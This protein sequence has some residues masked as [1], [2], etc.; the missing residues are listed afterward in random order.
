MPAIVQPVRN[1]ERKCGG[2]LDLCGQFFFFFL[3]SSISPHLA[4]Q[5]PPAASSIVRLPR[6]AI[7]RIPSPDGRWMLIFECPDN[8]KPRKLWIEEPTSHPQKLVREYQRNLAVGWA[9]D[10]KRFLVE[11]DYSSTASS[12]YVVEA[13]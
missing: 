6:G 2:V 4:A 13:V 9:P 12:T 10:S 11:D 1:K 8:G 7:T 5:A 3:F